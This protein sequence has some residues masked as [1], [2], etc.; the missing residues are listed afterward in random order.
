MRVYNTLS[1]NKEEFVPREEGKVA[2]YVCGP[3]VYNHIHIGNARTFLSFDVIRRYLEYKG[4]DVRF[5]QNITDVDD[6]I[7][8]RANEEG[9]P[10]AEV[11]QEYTEAFISAMRA[12]GVEDPTERPMATETIPMHDRDDRAAHRARSRVRRRRRRLL[13]G[14]ELPR[15]RQA[16]GPRHRRDAHA[17]ARRAPTS[18]SATRSTSRSGRRPSPASRTGPAPGARGAPA[19]T[20]SVRAMSEDEL[21]LPFDIHG[22][23]SDLIFPHHENEIAQSEA[24]TGVQFVQVLAARRACSRSTPRR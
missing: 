22:G 23:G 10:A 19:G 15:L 12:L 21:G 18:A 20:S 9:R 13:L 17:G 24:A 16:V 1:R 4:Y 14:A 3:T 11:A 5:I 2:M 6:K 7:I 8:N